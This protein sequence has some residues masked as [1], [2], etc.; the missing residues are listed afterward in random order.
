MITELCGWRNY[1]DE[2][3]RGDSHKNIALIGDEYS[4]YKKNMTSLGT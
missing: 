4:L 2:E 3:I 1:V